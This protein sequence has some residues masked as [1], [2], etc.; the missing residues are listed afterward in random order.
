MQGVVTAS[1]RTHTDSNEESNERSPDDDDERGHDDHGQGER[2]SQR[3]RM[4]DPRRSAPEQR[5][6]PARHDEGR[7]IATMECDDH[8]EDD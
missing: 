5:T 4:L 2:S 1:R 7:D 3:E 8:D 6:D